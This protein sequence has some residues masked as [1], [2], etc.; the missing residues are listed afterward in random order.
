MLEHVGLTVFDRSEIKAFYQSLLGLGLQYDFTMPADLSE[1]LFGIP[2]Q[3]RVYLLSKGNLKL[4]LFIS[5]R[6]TPRNYTHICISVENRK[7][8]IQ[9]AKQKGYE[10]TVVRREK[11]D[12]FFIR[13]KSNNLF[14]I[15]EQ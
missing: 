11:S 12:L 9:K 6:K 4:E 8:F 5:K 13:D 1:N 14:E 15:K 10:C 2:K 3:T 7:A